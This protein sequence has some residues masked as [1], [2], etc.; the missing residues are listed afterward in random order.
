MPS[1][2]GMAR[3]TPAVADLKGFP[4]YTLLLGLCHR[5]TMPAPKDL[6]HY[7]TALDEDWVPAVAGLHRLMPERF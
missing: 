7:E 3:D 6:V 2:T 4:V 1:V 5:F